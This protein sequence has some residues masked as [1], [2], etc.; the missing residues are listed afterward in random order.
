MPIMIILSLGARLI[1]G[2]GFARG[3]AYGFASIGDDQFL[4]DNHPI[5]TLENSAAYRDS[6]ML[7]W[8]FIRRCQPL[9]AENKLWDR[10]SA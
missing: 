9:E 4:I 10:C 6:I 2:G 7:V 1:N 5:N 8:K 3:L